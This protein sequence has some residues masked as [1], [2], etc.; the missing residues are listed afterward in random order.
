MAR[1]RQGGSETMAHPKTGN[2]GSACGQHSVLD[3]IENV[4]LRQRL[5]LL[6][7]FR[8]RGQR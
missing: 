4:A 2:L 6:P 7:T 5:P 3:P 8:S 1:L